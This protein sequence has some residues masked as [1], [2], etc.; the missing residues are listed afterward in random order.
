[1]AVDTGYEIQIDEEA[2]GD[3]RIGEAD[4]SSF[5][6]TDAI[7]KV[8]LGPAAGQ[9]N[10]QNQQRLAAGVWHTYEIAVAGRTYTVLLDGQPSTAF[11]AD[12]ADPNGQFRGRGAAKIR[13]PGSSEFRC[14]P[15]PS[16]SR[17]SVLAHR[18][19]PRAEACDNV[20]SRE[21]RS[22]MPSTSMIRPGVATRPADVSGRRRSRR[23]E[24]L[25]RLEAC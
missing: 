19:R 16:P 4:G 7:Y 24:R 18:R 8:P 3:T 9:Q 11:T 6:R 25:M 23:L 21:A 14:T 10:Y 5:N 13:I 12:P 2:R 20:V 1:M 22:T 17:T 15:A